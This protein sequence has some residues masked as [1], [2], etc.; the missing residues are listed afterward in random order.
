MVED[1]FKKTKFGSVVLHDHA[2][3]RVGLFVLKME[4]F[5]VFILYFRQP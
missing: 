1:D 4:H 5:N 3:K 2:K